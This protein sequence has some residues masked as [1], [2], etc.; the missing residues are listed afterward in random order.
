LIDLHTHT[1]E[2]DGSLRPAELVGGARRAGLQTLAITDHDTFAGYDQAVETARALKLEL[3]CGI[4]ITTVLDG[5]TAH[6]LGYFPRKPPTVAFREWLAKGQEDRRDRN[7]RLTKRLQELGLEVELEEVEALGRN[8]TGRPHFAKVLVRK[9]HASS[10]QDAFERFLGEG[11]P[12]F[13]KRHGPEIGEG[14]E[15]VRSAGGVASLAHP[16]RLGF[17]DFEEEA[18][19]IG[20]LAEAGLGAIEAYHSDYRAE[21]SLRYLGMA[22]RLGLAVSGGSDFHG[23][24]KPEVAL[25]SVAVPHHVLDSLRGAVA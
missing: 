14:I 3:V 6:L 19:T 20:M 8:M 15:K 17:R 5:R 18:R 16:T 13:V 1:T 25:G 12:G 7:R 23:E 11:K 10:V 21:D 4:E 22:A 2:S 9:G 24:A